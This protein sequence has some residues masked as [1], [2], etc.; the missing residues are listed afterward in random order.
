MA[1]AMKFSAAS[2]EKVSAFLGVGP[3]LLQRI[4]EGGTA[5]ELGVGVARRQHR[6]HVG[7]KAVQVRHR[8][9]RSSNP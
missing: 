8:R 7:V 6:G 2:A 4:A 9:A 1:G 3:H 5:R